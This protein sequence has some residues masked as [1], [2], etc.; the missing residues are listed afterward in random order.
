VIAAGPQLVPGGV[1]PRHQTGM[2]SRVKGPEIDAHLDYREPELV[3][4]V[5]DEVRFSAA[6]SIVQRV[7]LLL[8]MAQP[9]AAR[10]ELRRLTTLWQ[11]DYG[12]D[13]KRFARSVAVLFPTWLPT[14]L[15]AALPARRFALCMGRHLRARQGCC[16][17]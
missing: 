10:V 5:D 2:R 3:F 7:P 8:A 4:E 14:I 6:R 9:E 17:A 1:Q 16:S 12:T 11:F 13:R 15:F